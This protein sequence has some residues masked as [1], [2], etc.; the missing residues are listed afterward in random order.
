MVMRLVEDMVGGRSGSESVWWWCVVVVDDEEEED[1]D[2]DV[3]HPTSI[4][5]HSHLPLTNSLTLPCL[6]R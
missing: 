1:E 2:E 3:V 5:S 6:V 4:P